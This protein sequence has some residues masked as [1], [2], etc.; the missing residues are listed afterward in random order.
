MTSIIFS[1]SSS[2]SSRAAWRAPQHQEEEMHRPP[3]HRECFIRRYGLRYRC[4][5][6]IN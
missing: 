5:A 4:I 6:V 1:N 3:Q 2:E